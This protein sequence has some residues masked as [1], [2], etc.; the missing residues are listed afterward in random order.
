MGAKRERLAR[1]ALAVAEQVRRDAEQRLDLR[2]PL[3]MTDVLDVCALRRRRGRRAGRD[4]GGEVDDSDRARLH[5][6]RTAA[7]SG[8]KMSDVA[9]PAAIRRRHL[10]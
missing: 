10:R 9:E 1:P 2:R 5:D 8:V 3:G 7:L 6:G 4:G